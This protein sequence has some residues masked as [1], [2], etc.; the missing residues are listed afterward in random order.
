MNECIIALGTN[1]LVRVD[2][3]ANE[4]GDLL[5]GV[6]LSI[7]AKAKESYSPIV[8]VKDDLVIIARYGGHKVDANHLLIHGDAI[9]AMV[10]DDNA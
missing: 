1:V 7:G 4:P 5:R 9:L 6:V 8:L 10:I 2:H 3:W